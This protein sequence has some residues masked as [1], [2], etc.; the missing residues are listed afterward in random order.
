V[1]RIFAGV[2]LV[3]VVAAGV[4]VV[5]V[6]TAQGQGDCFDGEVCLY[7]GTLYSGLLES[8]SETIS[9][10]GDVANDRASSVLNYTSFV[11]VLY[12]DV[13][14]GG[15]AICLDPGF[16]YDDLSVVG[17]DD[18]ISSLAVEDVSCS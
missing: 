10:V 4:G 17:F 12:S 2:I 13:N 7:D 5:E 14:Y 1:K 11:V 8:T 15:F 16:G 9:Y 3:T 6:G 18:D